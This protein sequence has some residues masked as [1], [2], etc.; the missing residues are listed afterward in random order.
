MTVLA[1]AYQG[2]ATAG[3][4]PPGSQVVHE[5]PDADAISAE[6]DRVVGEVQDLQASKSQPAAGVPGADQQVENI[7]RCAEFM[8]TARYCLGYGW[9]TSTEDAVQ[10]ELQA[11]VV[12]ESARRSAAEE[13]GD[14]SLQEMIDH[15]STMS[16]DERASTDRRELEDA[17][18]GI[19]KFVQLEELRLSANPV[20]IDAPAGS[21][22]ARAVIGGHT[23][24]ESGGILQGRVSE[25][26]TTYWCGPTTLQMMAWNY[27]SHAKV[28]QSTWAT[29]LNTTTAG[30]AITDMVRV[31]N[32]NGQLSKWV[33]QQDSNYVTLNIGSYTYAQWYQLNVNHYSTWSTPVV[34]HPIL[35]KKYYPYLDDNGSGH[36]QLGRGWDFESHKTDSW[37]L[38][39]YEPWNQQ[40][41]NP[42]EPFIPRKQKRWAKNSY[43]ANKEH[44]QHNIG[45]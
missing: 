39:Y 6:I 5:I 22:G 29:R 35:L 21:V 43:L 17:A 41:F 32:N 33:T 30:T 4:P 3:E 42:S 40:R 38:K 24:P 9:T 7:F 23:Y 28:A 27:G 12:T 15:A 18:A 16:L 25:Q 36:F 11:A 10:A 19:E 20:S 44:F 37:Q 13:T 26:E 31:I 8:E 34:L 2:T 45:V 14:L 1:P